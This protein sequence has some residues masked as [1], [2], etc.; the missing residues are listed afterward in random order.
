MASLAEQKKYNDALKVAE[1]IQ[2][3]IDAG[4][5]VRFKT[6]EK[7]AGAEKTILAYNEKLTKEKDKQTAAAAKEQ[8]V[9]DKM[10]SLDQKLLKLAKS[11]TGQILQSFGMMEGL[12]KSTAEA[13]KVSGKLKEGYNL[14]SQA[15]MQ[16]IEELKSDTFDAENYVENVKDQLL[17]MGDEGVKAFEQMEGSLEDFA[18]KVKDSPDL[19]EKLKV[20]ADAQQK[21]DDFKDKVAETSAFLSSPKAMGVAAIGLLVKLIKDFAQKAL[22]VRQS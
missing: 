20:E 5:K 1:E 9:K 22:E 8:K 14:V 7:L 16:A 19:G 2:A 13:G 4:V 15:Q 10:V 12:T 18:K 21:I 3:K 17:A 6:L 11:S